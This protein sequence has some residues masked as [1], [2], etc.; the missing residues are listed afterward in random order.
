[1]AKH[2]HLGFGEGGCVG[3]DP[4][5]VDKEPGL[6]REL[7]TQAIYERH[8]QEILG[9]AIPDD[10][11]SED[12]RRCF[13]CG[14][15]DH[16]VSSCPEPFN[17]QLVALSRQMYNFFKG[18]STTEFLRIHELAEW[19]RQRAE[20]LETFEPG[21]IR[22]SLLR[23]ALNLRDED[24]GQY[25]EWLANI[26]NWGYPRGWLGRED[27]RSRV[28]EIIEERAGGGDS[29]A[30]GSTFLFIH[31][32]QDHPEEVLLQSS[33]PDTS[34]MLSHGADESNSSTLRRWAQYPATY[35]S[36]SLLPIYNGF[37]LP[38]I[39]ST[40]ADVRSSFSSKSQT[41][42]NDLAT[43]AVSEHP[44][45]PPSTAPPPLP[46]TLVTPPRT[47]SKLETSDDDG[48]SDMNF[49]DSD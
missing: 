18:E 13:N 20:W 46:P 24:E 45:P 2:T 4:F 14:S 30:H 31:G 23:E 39:G 11:E 34:S 15:P 29:D 37:T 41:L 28:W 35:F 12:S 42:R 26:A 21:R 9:E 49:S 47:Q 3:L 22:G 36:S 44:P 43:S 17:R 10:D 1:M 16:N 7:G 8:V 19:Q 32:E 48:E 5:Y 6:W 25:V 33:E 40:Q 38:P 27:P